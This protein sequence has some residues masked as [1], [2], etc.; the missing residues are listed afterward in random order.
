[1]HFIR[2]KVLAKE[3]EIR[4]IP[5]EEP[6][7]DILTKPLTFLHFNYFRAKLNV[8]TCPLSL[9]GD[10]KE[11]HAAVKGAAQLARVSQRESRV[12]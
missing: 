12:C 6:I 7:A 9:R 11:A 1:M 3:L 4:Y 10:V 5:S 2:D 8:L